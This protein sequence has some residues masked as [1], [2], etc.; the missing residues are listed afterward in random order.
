MS[1]GYS[2][3]KHILG[4]GSEDQVLEQDATLLRRWKHRHGRVQQQVGY[5]ALQYNTPLYS[6]IP[7]YTVEYPDIQ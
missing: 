3:K 4:D 5:S 7:R 1:L 6:R 2:L